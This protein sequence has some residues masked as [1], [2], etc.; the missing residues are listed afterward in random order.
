M[1]DTVEPATMVIPDEVL[2]E[3]LNNAEV[4]SKMPPVLTDSVEGE[5]VKPIPEYG[6]DEWSDYV[7]SEFTDDE[8]IEGSPTV[9]G[10]R[11]VTNKVLGDI[12]CSIAKVIQS[13]SPA[14]DYSATC[15]HYIEIYTH[16][17]YTKKYTEVAD[18]SSKN[19]D[20]E[21]ARY[22][23]AMASTR[24]EGRALRKAL[25]IKRV[26]AAEELTEVEVEEDCVLINKSQI[27]FLDSLCKRND[28]N[29]L[30]FI[31]MGVSK[32]QKIQDI[33][34]STAAKMVSVLSEYQRN[35]SK[36]PDAIKTYDANWRI[37]NDGEQ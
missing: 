14:N 26:V 36:I 34:H 37:V 31:N 22:P 30:K 9:D 21:Y 24:A 5:Q 12:V 16:D 19:T 35:H 17:G 3:A 25:M 18:V 33:P 6:S 2:A 23:T 28:I 10:L 20:P 1:V 32:Y 8:L 27:T 11:R 4:E 29:V 15:E 13:P 7:M